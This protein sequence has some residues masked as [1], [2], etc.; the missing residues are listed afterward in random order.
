MRIAYQI[1]LI[2]V[3][4]LL[5]MG[6]IIGLNIWEDQRFE[7]TNATIA[8]S[9][10]A[11][12]LDLKLQALILQAR[13]Y[14]KDFLL[15]RDEA[16]QTRHAE[17]MTRIGANIAQFKPLVADDRALAE[18]V[19]TIRADLGRYGEA[20]GALV[21]AAKTVGLDGYKG[22]LGDMRKSVAALEDRLATVDV[23]KAHLAAMTMR[24][25]EKEFLARL[26]PKYGT[27]IKAQLPVLS[28]ALDSAP[29]APDLR[30]ELKAKASDYLAAFD[31]VMTAVAEE[32]AH[33]KLVAGIYDEIEPRLMR[34][35][36]TIDARAAAASREA[37]GMEEWVHLWSEISVVGSVV[38]VVGLTLLIGLGVSRPIRG[39]TRAMEEL[40]AGNLDA[41]IPGD[42]RRD[43]IGTMLRAVHAFK[44]VMVEADRLRAD[45]ETQKRTAEDQRREMMM[46][47]AN[48]FETRVGGIVENVAAASTQLQTTAQAM[49]SVSEETSRQSAT[50]AAASEQATQ[51]VQTV[52][53]ATEELS[54]SI[55]EISQQ[56]TRTTTMIADSVRQA[57]LSNEDVRRLTAAAEKIGDVVK[58]I[59][60]IAGQ[61]NLLALNATIEAARAGD[62]GR[63]FAVVASEVKAL[64]AQ[65]AHATEEI[66]SQVKAIQDGTQSSA[67]M[68]EG[69]VSTI[70]LV[71]S[72]AASIAAAVEQQGA[73]TQEIS[74]NI[75]QASQGTQEVTAN[76]T[77]VSDASQQTG[78]AASQVLSSAVEL[79]RN[80]EAL[81]VQ[82]E[83][84][85][86]EVRAA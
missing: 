10:D 58:M 84:F 27:S 50:V 3:F 33:E 7:A 48:Q 75:I 60:D 37:E 40:A 77:G 12:D 13:R 66:A 67:R 23:P 68:I 14:E 4:G 38:A 61:T 39:V 46:E 36:E 70:G 63:G 49:A 73:A 19:E 9:R 45:Q 17:T 69:I 47:L 83:Y 34:L 22:L 44:A 28:A 76:M 82:V 24:R 78:A 52:A 71:N 65:T 25:F 80:S 21:Q 79:S 2:G 30:A 26:D 8:R 31:R 74:R 1:A 32:K 53:S 29:V 85:L 55:S 11:S 15:R 72:T 57:N 20:F 56:V 6:I 41:A 18:Q 62:A 42:Q 16:S 59:S 35:D 81:Q 86:Q 54:A 51:N 64:A 43:E 5:G